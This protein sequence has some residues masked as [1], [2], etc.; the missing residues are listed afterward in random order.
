MIFNNSTATYCAAAL[1]TPQTLAAEKGCLI[2]QS[3]PTLSG[4]ACLQ[5]FYFFLFVRLPYFPICLPQVV[6]RLGTQAMYTVL[7]TYGVIQEWHRK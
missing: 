5:Q 2:K 1:L 4:G 6:S 3:A 7:C